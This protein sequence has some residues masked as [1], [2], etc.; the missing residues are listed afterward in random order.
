MAGAA[1]GHCPD[2]IKIKSGKESVPRRI[3]SRAAPDL[4]RGLRL[5]R[6]ITLSWIIRKPA[7][8][9][10]VDT[11]PVKPSQVFQRRVR[12]V[13]IIAIRL[14]RWVVTVQQTRA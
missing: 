3:H 5:V 14:K 13:Y 7:R 9:L 8:G 10:P 2:L 6:R 1:V 4:I 11:R 12:P